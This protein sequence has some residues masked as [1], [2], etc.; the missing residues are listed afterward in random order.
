MKNQF[1]EEDA[2]VS[3]PVLE[4]FA[5]DNGVSAWI[6]LLY[7]FCFVVVF[8]LAAVLSLRFFSYSKR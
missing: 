8:F 1:T 7:E 5:L 6:Y 2:F 3:V 4:Y